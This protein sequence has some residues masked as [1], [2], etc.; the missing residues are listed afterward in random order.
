[1]VLPVAAALVGQRHI[2]LEHLG[3][4]LGQLLLGA[5]SQGRHS[6]RQPGRQA[7]G[8]RTG[9]PLELLAEL[10]QLLR[11]HRHPL[12]GQQRLE[13]RVLGRHAA[14][15]LLH[16]GDRGGVGRVVTERREGGH[17]DPHIVDLVDQAQLQ[18]RLLVTGVHLKGGVDPG[19]QLALAALLG[20]HQL[21]ERLVGAEHERRT[22]TRDLLRVDH[23]HRVG[24]PLVEG[25]QLR[26]GGVEGEGHGE[27]LTVTDLTEGRTDL[28]PR[29]DLLDG[30]TGGDPG[31]EADRAGE[32]ESD[33]A[34]AGND[35]LLDRLSAE[36][37]AVCIFSYPTGE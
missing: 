26:R 15:L 17:I 19:R 20:L 25:D 8:P 24:G 16:L 10:L 33:R 22:E 32:S 30:T 31:G 27:R 35:R 18:Q 6:G 4:R 9:L 23:L 2:P 13:G 12:V 36:T 37:A 11:V 7:R 34:Y 21:P 28:L 5:R 1:M 3:Q 29:G 14:D